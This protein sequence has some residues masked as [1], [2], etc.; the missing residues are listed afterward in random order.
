MGLKD[1]RKSGITGAETDVAAGRLIDPYPAV[2]L[3]LLPRGG[4]RLQI[5]D[6]QRRPGGERRSAEIVGRADPYRIASRWDLT[7]LKTVGVLAK[8][9]RPERAAA[10]FDR[11]LREGATGIEALPSTVIQSSAA[12]A[13][14]IDTL[15]GVLAGGV[16]TWTGEPV[17]AVSRPSLSTAVA[18]GV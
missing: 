16:P 1:L 3:M 11:D 2:H 6:P 17:T 4:H 18:T 12:S 10:E 8:D 14:V 9:G 7:F 5:F 15:G 13:W